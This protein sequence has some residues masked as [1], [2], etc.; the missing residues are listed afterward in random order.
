MSS[1]HM[2]PRPNSAPW[3]ACVSATWM[4]GSPFRGS[5]MVMCRSVLTHSPYTAAGASRPEWAPRPPGGAGGGHLVIGPPSSHRPLWTLSRTQIADGA[6]LVAREGGWVE[7]APA[8]HPPAQRVRPALQQPARQHGGPE[9]LVRRSGGM[10]LGG[11]GCGTPSDAQQFPGVAAP[12]GGC[13]VGLN[14]QAAQRDGNW[15]WT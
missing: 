9:T 10:R 5:G 8:G 1:A 12:T 13:S 15:V 6:R 3:L 2:R 4:N 7:G 14:L 11:A